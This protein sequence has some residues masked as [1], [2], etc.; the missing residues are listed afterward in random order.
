MCSKHKSASDMGHIGDVYRQFR[1]VAL[2][3]NAPYAVRRMG[4]ALFPRN[5]RAHLYTKAKNKKRKDHKME[6]LIN[7]AVIIIYLYIPFILITWADS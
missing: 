7:I 3:Y 4:F 1:P 5:N 2:R 6:N